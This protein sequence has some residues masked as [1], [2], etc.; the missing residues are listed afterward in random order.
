MVY[1]SCLRRFGG[2]L[3][4]RIQVHS[5]DI[6]LRLVVT[7]EI[8]SETCLLGLFTA[9]GLKTK[10]EASSETSSHTLNSVQLDIHVTNRTL[11]HFFF[12][13]SLSEF[14]KEKVQTFDC[15]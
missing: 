13:R 7:V 4:S 15:S 6:I 10:L 2:L 8:E 11:T 12:C 1:V 3:Y 5:F 14:F 9:C